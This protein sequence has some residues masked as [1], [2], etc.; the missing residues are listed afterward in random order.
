MKQ[1]FGGNNR[2]GFGFDSYGDEAPQNTQTNPPL[3]SPP[4]AEKKSDGFFPS[5]PFG[6]SFGSF[7]FGSPFGGFGSNNQT[8]EKDSNTHL[9][10]FSSDSV[11]DHEGSDLKQAEIM[12]IMNTIKTQMELMLKTEAELLLFF[13]SWGL[14]LFQ[15][16]VM[17]SILL[18]R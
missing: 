14:I 5:S 18:K 9:S 4:T 15:I 2:K 6:G 17:V 13:L 8:P 16:L 10:D 7:G 11:S 3:E 12:R 1:G